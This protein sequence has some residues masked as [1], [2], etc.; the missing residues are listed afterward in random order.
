[1]NKKLFTPR[2]LLIL[3][4]I[5]TAAF[6]RLIPHWPNFTP[7]A[8]IALFAGTYIGRKHLAFI[9][10][11]AAMLLSD[12]FLGLHQTM[13]AV[14]IS[15]AIIVG[16]GFLVRQRVSIFTVASASIVSSL[17]F[18]LITNFAAWQ[19]GMMPYP[20]NITGLLECYTAG[21]PFLNN[22]VLGDLFYNTVFFGGFYFIT[23]K[24]PQLARS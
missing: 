20:M 23:Q 6:M 16:I 7:I 17:L 21:L 14:Y 24:Y 4:V 22:A 11:L 10:P 12:L 19:S 13:L 3:T 5:F 1:M 2:F 15:F 18:F 8:G 9:I